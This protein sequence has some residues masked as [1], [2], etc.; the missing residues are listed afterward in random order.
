MNLLGLSELPS[1]GVS[2]L[3]ST[4]VS[5]LGRGQIRPPQDDAIVGILCW[6]RRLENEA[7]PLLSPSD[8]S[9]VQEFRAAADLLGIETTTAYPHPHESIEDVVASILAMAPTSTGMQLASIIVRHQSA[10]AAHRIS[11]L[12]AITENTIPV[13]NG[14][15]LHHEDPAEGLINLLPYWRLFPNRGAQPRTLITGDLLRDAVARSILFGLINLGAEVHA[16]TT[17]GF[18]PQ[19]FPVEAPVFLHDDISRIDPQ[20]I[21]SVPISKTPWAGEALF[22]EMEIR[23][24]LDWPSKLSTYKNLQLVVEVP[25]PEDA[26][27]LKCSSADA[28]IAPPPT[29][30][31][32]IA[33]R[34]AILSYCLNLNQN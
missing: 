17:P 4:A 8:A 12:T 10:G 31:E 11:R 3:L 23:H 6:L 1:D 22:P 32:R 34:A 19:T 9:P 33:V 7:G 26:L 14:G 15:D 20:V 30:V 21:V 25:V 29:E 16:I 28:R 2:R 27:R 24:L 5:F 13:V 18:T